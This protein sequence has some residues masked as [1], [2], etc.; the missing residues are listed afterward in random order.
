MRRV[1]A[2]AY[3]QVAPKRISFVAAV[4]RWDDDWRV[5]IHLI[6][7][8][9]EARTQD[10]RELYLMI[11]MERG[12]HARVEEPRGLDDYEPI[13]VGEHGFGFSA[14]REG[15]DGAPDSHHLIGTGRTR[16][17]AIDDLITQEWERG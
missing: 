6:D 7:V 9:L 14:V 5:G 2:H 4:K 13:E 10:Q 17:E 3:K 12:Y 15:Y 16:Y 1:S 11:S 8:Q